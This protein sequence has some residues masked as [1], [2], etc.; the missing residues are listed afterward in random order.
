MSVDC[1]VRSSTSVMP[2]TTFARACVPCQH[3]KRCV[4]RC[5]RLVSSYDLHPELTTVTSTLQETTATLATTLTESLGTSLASSL[6]TSLA[7]SITESV[8]AALGTQVTEA[9]ETATR[10]S[11]QSLPAIT[12]HLVCE[13]TKAAL[14][15]S[16]KAVE[17]AVRSSIK[18][19]QPQTVAPPGGTV[20]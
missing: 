5:A 16:E 18:S 4:T 15:S 12:A 14:S 8:T 11:T 10:A 19:I 9:V 2:T 13:K 3:G 6:S 7:A 1:A 20:S 17:A